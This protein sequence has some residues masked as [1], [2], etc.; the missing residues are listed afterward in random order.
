MDFTVIA[1]RLN[2][3]LEQL[4][5]DASLKEKAQK[6]NFLHGSA[7]QVTAD[8][9]EKITPFARV[10]VVAP[11]GKNEG[12]WIKLTGEM[13]KRGLKPVSVLFPSDFSLDVD[14][15]CGMFNLAEDVR[16]AVVFDD[17]LYSAAYYFAAVKGLPCIAVVNDLC[18]KGVLQNPVFIKNSDRL[19]TF[20]VDIPR[21]IVLEEQEVADKNQA[22]AFAHLCSALVGLADYRFNNTVTR[23]AP[24]KAAYDLLRTAVLGGFTI[25]KDKTGINEKLIFNRMLSEIAD[26]LTDGK[27]VT[28]SAPSISEYIFSGKFN[29]DCGAAL[30]SACVIAEAYKSYVSNDCE[31]LVFAPDYT[32]RAKAL[33]ELIGI[34]ETEILKNYRIQSNKKVARKVKIN[35]LRQK[36]SQEITY[37]PTILAGALDE[38]KNLGG[39]TVID[40]KKLSTAVKLSGDLPFYINGMSLLRETG[41]IKE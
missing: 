33:N 15:V 23:E 21:Y 27:L 26:Y 25:I 19:E 20:A 14:S 31:E 35:E 13:R 17:N 4:K 2:A 11:D 41:Y 30:A 39:Q 5:T 36:L 28:L 22:K 3:V 9:L 24:I 29:G 16:A 10:A 18:A 6:V 7:P 8:V 34:N 38:Y 1:S 32:E 12:L 40:T 37:F